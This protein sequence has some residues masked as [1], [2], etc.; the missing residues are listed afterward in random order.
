MIMKSY[1]IKL[2]LLENEKTQENK[3]I[4]WTI[5]FIQQIVL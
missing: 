2:L 3:Q 4:F 1:F 5:S